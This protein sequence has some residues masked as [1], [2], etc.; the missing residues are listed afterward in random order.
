MA[1]LGAYSSLSPRLALGIPSPCVFSQ[2]PCP[3]ALQGQRQVPTCPPPSST[4]APPSP[5][6]LVFPQ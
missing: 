3:L 5:A 2:S 1:L 4:P 6:C